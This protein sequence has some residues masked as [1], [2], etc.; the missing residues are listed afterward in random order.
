MIIL[1]TY[2]SKYHIYINRFAQIR[3][4]ENDCEVELQISLVVATE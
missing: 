3:N 2:I 1:Y 4:T